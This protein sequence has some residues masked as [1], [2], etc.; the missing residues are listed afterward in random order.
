MTNPLL[1]FD[2]PRKVRNHEDNG[3]DTI[4]ATTRWELG[5]GLAAALTPEHP[6]PG[7][8]QFMTLDT[9]AAP[10]E[11]G[12]PVAVGAENQ[13]GESTA[14]SPADHVHA[15]G[16]QTDPDMH[17][18]AT[19]EAHGFMDK[20]MVTKLESLVVERI[21]TFRVTLATGEYILNPAILITSDTQVYLQRHARNG[22]TAKG[23]LRYELTEGGPGDGLIHVK[24][25]D[26][27]DVVVTGDSSIVN[28]EV[29]EPYIAPPP[30]P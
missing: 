2:S 23:E 5:P 13:E 7:E 20:D 24:A 22:S 14:V 4:P 17:A 21:I 27:D 26:D 11:Y 1:Q 25:L 16:N 15:H 6:E 12:P 9:T 30:P 3:G 10:L 29:V 28:V 19:T 18:L 8:P